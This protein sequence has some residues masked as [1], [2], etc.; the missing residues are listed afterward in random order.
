MIA[1]IIDATIG[2][3]SDVLKQFAV[4]LFG[5]VLFLVMG[6]ICIFGQFFI[7][8]VV[9][10][11]NKEQ[12]TNGIHFGIFEKVVTIVQYI[13]TAIMTIVAIQIIFSSRYYTILINVAVIVSAG[14]GVYLMSYLSFWFFSWFRILKTIILLLYGLASAAIVIFL[15]STIILFNTILIEKAAVIYPHSNVVFPVNMPG[16]LITLAN[17]AQTYSGL[18][19]FILLWCGTT[20]LLSQN[21]HRIGRVK[22]WILLSMPLVFFSSF[23]LSIYQSIAGTPSTENLLSGVVMPVLLIIFSGIVAISLIGFS[24]FS[25]AK[26]LSNNTV[27]KDYMIIT[28]YGFILFFTTTLTSIAGLGFPP[29]GLLNVLLIGPFSFLISSSFYNSAISVAED[30]NLR[31]AIKNTTN[32]ELKLLD[33]M[34]TAKVYQEMETKITKISKANADSLTELTGI[35][36]SLT[37]DEIRDLLADIIEA[38]QRLGH[39][40]K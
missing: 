40:M 4:S 22:F 27:I 17:T 1:Q 16:T 19:A 15:V 28:S 21:I 34:G 25:I 10:K 13:L 26:P 35:E 5:I 12:R 24:F 39:Q 20:I 3:L 8:G 37:D 38:K 7:L 11:R 18:I 9:K 29:F 33:D 23:Y 32:L 36:P 14:L 31:R 30:M 6:G 2:N